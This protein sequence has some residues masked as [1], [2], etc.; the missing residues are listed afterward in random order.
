MAEADQ[1]IGLGGEDEFAQQDG[2]GGENAKI[3]DDF[4]K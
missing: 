1:K 2:G 4:G 3:D